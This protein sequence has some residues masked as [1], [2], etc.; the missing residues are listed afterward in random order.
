MS[1][2]QIYFIFLLYSCCFCQVALRLD[3]IQDY[4]IRTTQMTVIN[5]FQQAQ[6]PLT[7]GIIAN[8]YG[9]D[10]GLVSFIN[11]RLTDPNFCMEIADHGGKI[12]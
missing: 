6:I 11:T 2:L 12:I 1:L 4:W 10:T 9:T 5:M 3:D 7:I 8:Y